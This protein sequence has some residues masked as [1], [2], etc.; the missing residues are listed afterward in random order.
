M[1]DAAAFGAGEI[2]D[3]QQRSDR[4]SRL[5]RLFAARMLGGD[6]KPG[7]YFKPLPIVHSAFE[8]QH[9]ESRSW[10]RPHGRAGKLL[11]SRSIVRSVLEC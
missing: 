10:I 3:E 5:E 1:A 8:S 11:G 2:I 6:Q 4:R 9:M 7:E